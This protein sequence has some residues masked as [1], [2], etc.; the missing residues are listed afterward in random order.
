MGEEVA[1]SSAA[2]PW[3]PHNG[4]PRRRHNT[5]LGSTL[6]LPAPRTTERET[7]APPP[8]VLPPVATPPS[9]YRNADWRIEGRHRRRRMNLGA[10]TKRD[11][12][13]GGCRE[14][15]E[16][17]AVGAHPRGRRSPRIAP[18]VVVPP[19]LRPGLGGGGRCVGVEGGEGGAWISSV[20][21]A[22]SS[23][24]PP[25]ERT[26]APLAR[27]RG[28]PPVTAGGAASGSPPPCS[29][30]AL[31][32]RRPAP[33]RPAAPR[34]RPAPSRPRA[35]H[36]CEARQSPLARRCIHGRHSQASRRS[37]APSS[38][39]ARGVEVGAR[40]WGRK[41]RDGRDRWG[42]LESMT[43]VSACW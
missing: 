19:S 41:E 17:E 16:D 24:A 31:P 8:S 28:P 20:A 29:G 12:E 33:H 27:A 1:R 13:E 25:P 22:R 15:L 4:V 40:W 7:G 35:L 43:F 9:L 42:K 23:T 38:T 30:R 3:R 11:G 21:D 26:G 18:A 36:R 6:P 2:R 37:P 14:E 10:P 39:G 32:R 34:H 5:G